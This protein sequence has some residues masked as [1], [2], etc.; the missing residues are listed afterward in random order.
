MEYKFINNYL[1]VKNNDKEVNFEFFNNKTL[2]VYKE[3]N[4][5]E[6]IELNLENSN[7]D[8]VKDIKIENEI[9]SFRF[10]NFNFYIDNNLE[11][12][13][14]KL[15]KYLTTL[16]L[17]RL[18]SDID[19]KDYFSIEF[20][21]SNN[22]KV[23][24]LGDKMSYLN[25]KGYFYSSDNTDD[26]NHQ[27]ELF[28]SLYKSINY[29]LFSFDLEFFGSFYPSTYKY[30]FNI[31][32]TDLNKLIISNF[33]NDCDLFLFLGDSLK[34]ITSSY[35]YL[36]GYPYF[37]RLK[38]L[39][40]NQSRWSYKNEDEVK[41]VFNNFKK[42]NLP[43]DYIHLDINYMDGYRD[44]TVDLNAFKNLKELSLFLKEK[45]VELVAINDAGIK[46]DSKYSIYKYLVKN[47]LV[48]LKDNKNY[49]NYVWPGRTV[50]PSYINQ[51]CKDY[52]TK[53]GYK[54]IKDNMISGIWNDMNEPV[55]F[56]GLLPKDVMFIGDNKTYLHDEIHNVYA[57]HMVKDQ[58]KLFKK[59][60]LRPY[61]FTRAAFATTP[62][63]AFCW[64]GDNFSLWHHLRYSIPQNLS[65]S[66]SNFMF[67]GVDVGGF[68]GDTNKELLIRWI[69]ANLFIPFL[70]NHSS[71]NTKSQEPYAF[72]EETL[73]IYR[74][75]LEIR[76]KFI[77]YLY[78]LSYRMSHFGETIIRPM[79]F[80]EV[81]E[82]TININDQYMVGDSLLIAPILNK[83]EEHRLIYLPK[84][85][86][87]DYFTNEIIEGER[88]IIKNISL[89]SSGYYLKYNSIIPSYLK[90]TS[91][92]KSKI[93]TIIFN[94]IGEHGEYI[95][96]ED[97]GSS[98]NYQ[99]GKYN[100]YS[101]KFNENEFSLKTIHKGY[102]STYKFIIVK[103]KDKEI[104]LD[105]KYNLKIKL[106]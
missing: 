41:E 104:K 50:F 89:D 75:F 101:L 43:L 26:S 13:I 59:D 42:Y 48:G 29:L 19:N 105:F 70:R 4:P 24:G 18:H 71:L 34:E 38:M 73:N 11:I 103:Y 99:K 40:N 21:L 37:I 2:R 53:V 46:Q 10:F 81:N 31:G 66:I 90:M 55:S 58:Y 32:Q 60:N 88:Y 92:N 83:D 35:S 86:W 79:F 94:L 27:D 20:D 47:K 52:F 36:V 78:D 8:L 96:Y 106:K 54:F 93:D 7:L 5:C 61:V 57:E 87:V 68:G 76:Y 45:D 98:L 85:K 67:T 25:K 65:L 82:I 23:F 22:S 39:G 51:K 33:F 14:Y 30:N 62:K 9:L 77:P 56:R 69:E 17:K 95:N 3:K 91:L 49:V 15:D 16:S 1:N 12:K 74:K 100:L 63:Y 102:K 84:G 44:Y 72:D 28:P 80:E 64:G 6:L 97:D